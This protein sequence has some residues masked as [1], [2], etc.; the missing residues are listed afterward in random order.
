MKRVSAAETNDSGRVNSREIFGEWGGMGFR[1]GFA[2]GGRMSRSRRERSD[3][4]IGAARFQ[5]VRELEVPG[6]GGDRT[7]W[8]S[9][10]GWHSASVPQWRGGGGDGRMRVGPA[11]PLRKGRSGGVPSFADH[12]FCSRSPIF[13][14]SRACCAPCWRAAPIS[15]TRTRRSSVQAEQYSTVC[16]VESR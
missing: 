15:W 4:S 1:F 10:A 7:S 12:H 3:R 16:C 2:D 5:S 14:R 13:V 6:R 8:D 11:A 9:P